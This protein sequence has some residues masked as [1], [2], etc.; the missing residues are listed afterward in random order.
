MDYKVVIDASRGG[1][2]SGIITGDF[3]EKDLS[4]KI[5]NYIYERL[6]ELEVP[7]KMIRTCDETIAPTERVNRVLDAYGNN[8]NVIVL[9]NHIDVGGGEWL[10]PV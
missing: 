10:L 3:I 4:L 2:D 1:E 9:S 5:S 8:S 6:N 7:V